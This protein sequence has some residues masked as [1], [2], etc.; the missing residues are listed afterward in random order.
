MTRRL[1]GA[2]WLSVS[3]LLAACGGGGGGGGGPSMVT[4][5]NVVGLAQANAVTSITGAGLTDT[6]TTQADA[7]IATGAVV[8]E[9]PAAG[10]SVATGTMVT[11]VVSS[12]PPP[13]AVPDVVGLTQ[14]AAITALSNANLAIGVV[15]TQASTAVAAGLVISQNPAAGIT[16][17]G[18]TAVALV[19]SAGPPVTVPNV[20]GLNQGAAATLISGL[21]L[22]VGSATNALSA[23]VPAGDVISQ[24]P[25][26]GTAVAV[27]SAVTLVIS[28]GAPVAVPNVVGQ[29]QAAATTAIGNAGL[30]LGTGTT[31]NSATIPTGSVI[32]QN[33]AAGTSVAPG[34]A[35]ALVISIGAPA[36]NTLPVTID[37]GP[38]SLAAAGGSANVMYATVTVCTPGSTT[39]CQT[40][41]HVEVDTGSIGLRILSEVL[42][43]SAVP[44][45]FQDPASGSPLIGC[46]QFADG[47]SWGSMVVAD[48][49]I[50]TRHIS[51]LPMHLIGDSAAGTAPTSCT[52]SLKSENTVVSFGANGILG[53]GYWLEDCGS[54][55]ASSPQTGFYYVC[56]GGTCTPTTVLQANQAKNP[57]GLFTTDN[58]GILIDLPA[59]SPPGA[60][61]L[62]G[63]IYFGVGTQANNALG[64]ALVYTVDGFGELSTFINSLQYRKSFID[65]GSNGYFF[66]SSIKQCTTAT[67]FYCPATSTPETATIVGRNTTSATINFT[68]DNAE[69][70]FAVSNLTAFPN[71]AGSNSVGTGL[72]SSVDWGL[73]FF[74]NR[75]VYVLFESYS[76]NGTSGPASA[77]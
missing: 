43:G 51:N 38:A 63:T 64:T 5:P 28:L 17:A 73:P 27:G 13:V 47:Y 58:N 36:A 35:V 69:Q 77:F 37:S 30:V 6:I 32:S 61:T 41:D 31:Q 46:V 19:V 4:I 2:C 21:G 54:A 70:L 71:L 34:T 49:T 60:P 72:S 76:A 9:S 14:A 23:T 15:T 50:G 1:L 26:A 62:Q 10:T 25:A 53:I 56:P 18:N 65:S 48:V 66:S 52:N 39:A 68:V 11:L 29:T 3:L 55:C 59:V 22:V 7:N 40:I 75:K 57:V 67:G 24:S 45:K 74:F 42:T 12:G 20:V 8:S 33:P 44:A 16:V